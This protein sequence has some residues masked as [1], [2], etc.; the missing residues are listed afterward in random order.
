[1]LK[2]LGVV[3]CIKVRYSSRIHIGGDGERRYASTQ[4]MKNSI[5]W[6]EVSEKTGFYNE[7]GGRDE[8]TTLR[9]E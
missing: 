9:V 8:L 6:Y 2:D 5:S 1:M 3:G 7:R 4:M